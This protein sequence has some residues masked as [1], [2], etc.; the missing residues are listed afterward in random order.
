MGLGKNDQQTLQDLIIASLMHDLGLSQ[1]AS[2]VLATP[3]TKRTPEQKEIYEW[4]STQCVPTLIELG[5]TP[6]QRTTSILEQHHERFDGTGYP[7][8]LAA[9]KIEELA[10]MLCFAD[11]LD[12][13]GRG[14]YDGISRSLQESIGVVGEIERQ[15]SFPRYFNPDLFKKLRNWL[16]KGGGTDYMESVSSVVKETQEKLSKAS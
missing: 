3:E 9:F 13:I 5:Y 10:Q 11:L 4:H 12:T 15:T 6:N 2:E 14:H 7:K 8:H 16:T 1:I